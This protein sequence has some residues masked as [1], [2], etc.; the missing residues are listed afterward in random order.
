VK[1]DRAGKSHFEARRRS[2]NKAYPGVA[3][4]CHCAVA[5]RLPATTHV[6]DEFASRGGVVKPRPWHVRDQPVLLTLVE[7]RAVRAPQQVEPERR[8]AH[9]RVREQV[10]IARRVEP[11]DLCR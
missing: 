9:R 3:S 7:R 6:C 11:I 8:E 10:V 4:G 1:D 2:P 5:L